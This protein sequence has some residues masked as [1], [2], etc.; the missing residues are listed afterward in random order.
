VR[1]GRSYPSEYGLT[2]TCAGVNQR[3]DYLKENAVAVPTFVV[4]SL[5]DFAVLSQ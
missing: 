3:A 4:Q 5:G 2:M 1:I